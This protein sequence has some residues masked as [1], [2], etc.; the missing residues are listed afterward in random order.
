M[1]GDPSVHIQ[2][3]LPQSRSSD[4]KNSVSFCITSSPFVYCSRG[5]QNKNSFFRS[6]SWTNL[7]KAKIRSYLQTMLTANL[8]CSVFWERGFS[9]LSSNTHC[10]IFPFY[11]QQTVVRNRRVSWAA[12]IS[13]QSL[14]KACV[15]STTFYKVNC[16]YNCIQSVL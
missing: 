5:L 10:T 2:Q 9:S 3:R 6:S 1:A 11:S 7:T 16:L 14:E 15:K 8:A 12:P 4:S 13:W